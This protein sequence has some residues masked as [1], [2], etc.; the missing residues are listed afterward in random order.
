MFCLLSHQSVSSFDQ[1][2]GMSMKVCHVFEYDRILMFPRRVL[3]KRFS[4]SYNLKTENY[5]T[6]TSS[7]EDKWA[8]LFSAKASHLDLSEL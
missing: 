1:N 8:V 6:V 5:A 3:H 7:I 2:M 4:H